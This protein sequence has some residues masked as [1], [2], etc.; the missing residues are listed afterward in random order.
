M[1]RTAVRVI[2]HAHTHRSI[3]ILA[4][5]P[6]V[7]SEMTVSEQGSSNSEF[8]Q[9]LR[10]S[11]PTLAYST[12]ISSLPVHPCKTDFDVFRRT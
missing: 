12:M 6:T 3:V 1:S 11:P 10:G 5:S 7:S 8:R 9:S 2:T 4:E